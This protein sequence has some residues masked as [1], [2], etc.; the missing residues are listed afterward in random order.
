MTWGSNVFVIHGHDADTLAKLELLIRRLS[1]EPWNL[2]RMSKRGSETLIEI[3]GR[4]VT[5]A[6]A[7]IALMTPDDEGREKGTARLN[8]RCRENVLIEAG[9]AL[10]QKRNQSLIVA[11]GGVKLP[12]DLDG[13]HVVKAESWNPTVAME[14]AKRLKTINWPNLDLSKVI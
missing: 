14:I 9:Y 7:L 11:L 5:Q 8:P 13:I 12:S 2:S 6:D 10:L 3:L 1:L 4:A